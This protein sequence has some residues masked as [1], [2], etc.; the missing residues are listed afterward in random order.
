MLLSFERPARESRGAPPTALEN[1]TVAKAVATISAAA[2]GIT[3]PLAS[4]KGSIT[5]KIIRA[6]GGC[7]GT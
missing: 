6:H 3:E 5:V 4:A 7:L 2:T 1:C